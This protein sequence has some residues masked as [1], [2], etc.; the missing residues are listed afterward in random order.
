MKHYLLTFFVVLAGWS[1]TPLPSSA[2][3]IPQAGRED[4]RI[5]TLTYSK[6]E[7]FHL[8]GHYGFTTTIEFSPK[9]KIETLSIGDSEAWQIVKPSQ[10]NLLFIKPI[11][12]NADTNMTL[13]TNKRMYNF[14][15][16]ASKASSSRSRSMVFYIKFVYPEDQAKLLEKIKTKEANYNPLLKAPAKQWNFDYSYAGDKKL[17]PDKV[18]DDGKSTYFMMSDTDVTPAIFAVDRKGNESIVN[19]IVKKPYLIVKRV[20]GQ[21]TLRDGDDATCIFNEKYKEKAGKQSIRTPISKPNNL[22][23]QTDDES[24]FFSFLKISPAKLPNQ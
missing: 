9:E 5:R 15:L 13:V 24:S 19:F 14:V 4:T 7:V 12:K 23:N 10:P 3:I 18:F 2:E 21:F 20:T 17:R 1:L 22:V 11:E 16:S 8:K 6:D